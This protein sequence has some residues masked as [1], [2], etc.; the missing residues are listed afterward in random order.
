MKRIF[1]LKVELGV[2][3][4]I[5]LI[6]S[7]IL[8]GLIRDSRIVNNK[9]KAEK[10]NYI[11]NS[12]IKPLEKQVR[13][14]KLKPETSNLSIDNL[15]YQKVGF[16]FYIVN[17]NGDVIASNN[18]EVKKIDSSNIKN[19]SRELVSDNRN[20]A[21]SRITF[22][23]YL[24]NGYYL[25]TVYFGYT[26]TEFPTEISIVIIFIVLFTLFSL[27][28]IRYIGTIKKGI[29]IITTGDLSYRIPLK[30]KNELSELAE[31]I[32]K[33]AQELQNEDMKRKEF[34]TNI[35]H[36][37]RTPLTSI[38]GY[39]T[40]IKE[41]KYGDKK[42]FDSYLNKMNR[43]STFL[44]SMLDDF[45]KYSRLSSGDIKLIIKKINIQELIRQLI[46]EEEI[47]FKNNDLELNHIFYEREVNILGDGELIVRAINNLLSNALKYS[48]K[49][50]IV[51]LEIYKK[52]VREKVYAVV[53][54][55]NTPIEPISGIE[56]KKFFQRLYKKD[57]S[58]SHEGS[59]LGLAITQEILRLHHGLVD[60]YIEDERVIFKL[61]FIQE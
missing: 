9:S 22:C 54:I 51:T 4:I 56:I 27:G 33:M 32:N 34:L 6:I 30:Y 3:A 13:N 45:F 47:V 11:Y 18:E 35:S 61:F 40:M 8:L 49:H 44:K 17:K 60:A 43:K 29:R 46:E 24:N 52:I 28:R 14:M 57:K 59:G 15:I 50:T 7:I 20:N 10:I 12:Q 41:K 37:L 25:Y 55:S 23:D 26:T 1:R 39:L 21:L 19:G 48:K 16:T 2:F 53:S 5:S 31:D 42:E 58:R 38:I 36:D